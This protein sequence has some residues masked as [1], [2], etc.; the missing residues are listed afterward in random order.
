MAI[1]LTPTDT[2]VESPTKSFDSEIEKIPAPRLT[3]LKKYSLLSLFCLAQ[4]LDTF[5]VSALFSGI[6]TI[7]V[8]LG[9]NYSE[10]TWIISAFQLTF[11]AFL[12][13]VRSSRLRHCI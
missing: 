7:T 1:P 8:H 3:T 12:L 13:V 11:A 10:A 4:F 6:P 2:L 5:N 9:I